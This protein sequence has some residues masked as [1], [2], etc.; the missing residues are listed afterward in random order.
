MEI[1]TNLRF[2]VDKFNGKNNFESWKLK[3]HDLLTQ[4]GFHKAL[5]GKGN[6]RVGM[7]DDEWEDI[8][9]M[10]LNMIRLCLDKKFLFNITREEKI[11]RLWRKMES[12]YMKKSLTN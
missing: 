10:G 9:V 11:T 8:E 3:M 12:F 5:D 6:N 1:M 2:E 4:Q 7:S